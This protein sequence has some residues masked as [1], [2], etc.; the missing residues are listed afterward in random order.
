MSY[1]S[2][3]KTRITLKMDHYSGI[4]GPNKSMHSVIKDSLW[5]LLVF[6]YYLENIKDHID[7][8]LITTLSVG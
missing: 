1:S 3:F 2:P 7:L 5:L 8:Y 4:K 6:L